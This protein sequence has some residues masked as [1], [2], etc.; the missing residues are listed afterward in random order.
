VPDRRALVGQARVVLMVGLAA[1]GGRDLAVLVDEP[2]GAASS[3]RC[4]VSTR[5]W[6]PPFSALD[7]VPTDT[8]AS[9][10]TSLMVAAPRRG[11]LES[12]GAGTDAT[13]NPFLKISD[14]LVPVPSR[15][16]ISDSVRDTGECRSRHARSAPLSG[17]HGEAAE[18]PT[19]QMIVATARWVAR[20]PAAA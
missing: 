11:G 8:P 2:A 17:D 5:S 18:A 20:V 19:G 10:A 14:I 1:D 6:P 3:T 13:E 16:K 4:L 15:V 12:G 9:L 7:T